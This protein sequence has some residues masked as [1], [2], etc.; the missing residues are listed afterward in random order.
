[1]PLCYTLVS[2][3]MGIILG[4][5]SEL[6]LERIIGKFWS[7]IVTFNALRYCKSMQGGTCGW[8]N[9]PGVHSYPGTRCWLKKGVNLLRNSADANQS[10]ESCNRKLQARSNSRVLLSLHWFASAP[11]RGTYREQ[12]LK[13]TF[14]VSSTNALTMNDRILQ[15][16]TPH[17]SW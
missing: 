15:Y 13:K 7:I 9:S 10:N 3:K 12:R 6:F 8:N 2:W 5:K 1:M 17:H 16:T 14:L 4:I 11:F